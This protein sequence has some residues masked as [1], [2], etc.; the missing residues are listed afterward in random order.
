M[1]PGLL[2][3]S[4]VRRLS[5]GRVVVL[6]VCALSF[7]VVLANRVPRF[8]G[9]TDTCWVSGDASHISAK[10]LAKDFFVLQP[11]ATRIFTV[12]RWQPLRKAAQRERPTVAALDNC[13]YNRPPPAA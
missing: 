5:Y 13:L 3:R 9:E 11:P 10:L 4:D 1:P 8:S 2:P 7:V 12:L 6:W